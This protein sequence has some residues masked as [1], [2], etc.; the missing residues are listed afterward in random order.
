MAA[1]VLRRLG[2]NAFGLGGPAL[3]SAGAEL[4]VE[5]APIAAMGIGAVVWRAP[6]IAAAA[7]RLLSQAK[8]RKPQAALL[9]GFSEFHAWLGPRLR[10]LGVRV[11]WYGPPQIWAWRRG[12]GD[13][14]RGACD[15]MAVVL[16][17]EEELWRSHGVDAHFVGH[18]SLERPSI[19]R[20]AARLK[21]GLTP[22]AEYVAVLPGSRREEVERHLG[23][24]LAAVA[25]LRADRGALDARVVVAPALPARAISWVTA[26]ADE[27]GVG[28]LESTAPP[29][30]PAFDAALAASGSVTL[31]CAVA[32]V[33][34]VIGYRV[35]PITE[36]I[37]RRLLR[38]DAVGLPNV[39]LGEKVFP[40]LLQRAFSPEGLCEQA[41]R[42][43][44]ARDMWVNK[45]REVRARLVP[46]DGA[47]KSPSERVAQ[48]MSP[49]LS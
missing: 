10:A 24:M 5:L 46:E 26:R 41:G 19:S 14:L 9:V 45:C 12:R 17:F 7:R 44:D 49:W 16:S 42:I 3:A 11:L 8:K 48:L 30:L 6:A 35:G 29:V 38:V 27:A 22:W 32:E 28:V 23:P 40:E 2:V 34:P 4:V 33:P 36:A 13:G 15:R 47:Q 39:V 37:A 43:L 31:E 25:L 21:L 20:E 18:P 1:P